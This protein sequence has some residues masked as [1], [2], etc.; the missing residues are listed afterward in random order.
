[1][2]A[3]CVIGVDLGGT[4]LLAGVVDSELNVRHRAFRKARE[5]HDAEGLID[6]LVSTVEQAREAAGEEIRAVGFGIPS[7]VDAQTG[8]ANTTV[9]LPLRDVPFRDVMAERLGLPVA[10]DNDAN[11]AMVAEHRRGAARGAR[12]AALLT[13]GTGIGGGIIVDDKIVHGASGAAGEWGHMVVD[14]NGPLCTCGNRGCLE[15]VVSGTALGREAAR[16]AHELPD[17]GFGRAL[18][19]GRE[20]SGMLATELAHDGDPVARDVV[21]SVGHYLGVG[22]GNVVNILNPEVVVVGG[23]VIAAGELLLEPA[24]RVVAERALAPSRDQVRIVPTR[25][26]DASGMIGAALLAMDLADGRQAP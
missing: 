10:V 22:I 8:V 20:I 4:K 1:M 14:V 23:G 24:R 6:L 25:F 16:M 17:S 9:H 3:G 18:A 19:A 26:G 7:L 2:A 5:G 11:G 12:T 21:A 13:L 15:T